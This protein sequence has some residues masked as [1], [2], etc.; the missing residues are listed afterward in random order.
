[1][2]TTSVG[3]GEALNRTQERA[4]ERLLTQDPR[5]RARPPA[6]RRTAPPAVWYPLCCPR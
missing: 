5:G 2:L 6:G 4:R 3:N 1:M